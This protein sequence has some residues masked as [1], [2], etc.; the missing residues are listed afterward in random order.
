M[1]SGARECW[2]D[3]VVDG[4]GHGEEEGEAPDE[5]QL[6]VAVPELGPGVERRGDDLIPVHRDGRH[7]EGGDKHG[8]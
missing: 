7:C 4:P 8:D 3:C 6:P 5:N 2:L 1:V